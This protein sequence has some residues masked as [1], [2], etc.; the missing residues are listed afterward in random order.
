MESYPVPRGYG[1]LLLW[2]MV[3]AVPHRSKVS[4]FERPLRMKN[5]ARFKDV[6]R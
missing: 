6:G 3:Q 1:T 2:S 4:I 5:D